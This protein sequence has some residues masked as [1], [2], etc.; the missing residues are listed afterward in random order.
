MAIKDGKPLMAFGTPG[1]DVQIQ[2][3][4]QVYLNRFVHGMDIQQAIEAPRFASYNYPSSFAPNSYHPGLLMIE[5]SLHE[6]I[7]ED[8]NGRGHKVECWQDGTW[9]AGGVLAV[10]RDPDSGEI[11]AGADPRRAGT[12]WGA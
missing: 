6:T 1:G 9:K 5:N 7:A 11:Q 2:A 3:M 12:A 8:L 4:I 10:V